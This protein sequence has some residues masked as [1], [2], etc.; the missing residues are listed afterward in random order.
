MSY[1]DE[2]KKIEYYKQRIVDRYLSQG[3]I[4]D[5]LRLQNYIDTIDTKLSL[6]RQAFIEN[7]ETLDLDK[8]NEQKTAL[9]KDLEILYE[10]VFELATERLVQTEAYVKCTINELNEIAKKY[11][12]K[13]ALESMSIYGN[14]IYYKTNGFKQYYLNG[15]V[16]IDLGPMS[17]PSGST[18]ACLLDSDEVDPKDIIF[19]FDDNTQVG[20]YLYNKNYLFIPGNYN[21]NTYNIESEINYNTNFEV[22]ISTEVNNTSIYN[23]FAGED[24]VKIKYSDTGE[25]EYKAKT[26]NIP[27]Q[28]D[29]DAEISFYI[30]D[31]SYIEIS[32]NTTPS[33]KNFEGNSITSPKLRQKILLLLT[34]GSVLD[35]ATDGRIF[36][37]MVNCTI[38]NDKLYS[39]S[40]FPGLTKFMV[41]EI[42]YGNPVEFKNVQVSANNATTT[43]YDINSIAIKQAQIIDIDRS[44]LL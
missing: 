6:F 2:L 3:Q 37:N 25:I 8:F 5:K 11:K 44:E 36:A 34:A 35:F 20:D 9:Y 1:L 10:L 23:L 14:T 7:G 28:L 43:F 26:I 12:Y 38:S 31:S 27:I 18:L 32:T 29:R 19:R 21:I 16:Y 24:Y 40:E 41:E 33:Y 15:R 39:T 4:V 22:D 13:T 17:I 42:D 30:Y